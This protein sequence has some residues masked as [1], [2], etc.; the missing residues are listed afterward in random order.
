MVDD[1]KQLK[2]ALQIIQMLIHFTL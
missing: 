2:S 1:F